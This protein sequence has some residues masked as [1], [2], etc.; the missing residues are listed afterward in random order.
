MKTSMV[1]LMNMNIKINSSVGKKGLKQ[2]RVV[3]DKGNVSQEA[4]KMLS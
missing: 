1:V 3:A 4:G 2:N